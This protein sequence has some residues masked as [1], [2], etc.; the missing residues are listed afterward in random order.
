MVASLAELLQG[1]VD[2]T[3][4]LAKASI[5][6]GLALFRRDVDGIED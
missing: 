3:I 4:G 6:A 2:F 1:G 5:Q